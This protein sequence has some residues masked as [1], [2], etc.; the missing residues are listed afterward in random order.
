VSARRHPYR[1]DIGERVLG[2]P[3]AAELGFTFETEEVAP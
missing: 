1:H 3:V 2:L